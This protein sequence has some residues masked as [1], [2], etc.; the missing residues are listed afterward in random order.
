MSPVDACRWLGFTPESGRGAF[1]AVCAC[2]W[3]STVE[4]TAGAAARAADA[5]LEAY[6]DV[7]DRP[8]DVLLD[9]L[10]VDIVEALQW[11]DYELA[12]N[13]AAAGQALIAELRPA[14]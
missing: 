7:S 10:N 6:V 14:A 1:Q 4:A 8:T 12:S 13:L 11:F 9:R 3:R 5:H 2:G